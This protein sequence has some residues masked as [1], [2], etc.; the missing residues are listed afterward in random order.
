MNLLLDK[1]QNKS[2]NITKHT[3]F[4]FLLK[5]ISVLFSF[6]TI[7]IILNLLGENDYG[8]WLTLSSITTWLAYLDI[9]LGNGL[10]N[11]LSI[12]LVKNDKILA[13]ELIS[14]TYFIFTI[15]IIFAVLII[16][17]FSKFLSWG[18]ILNTNTN[19]RIISNIIVILIISTGLKLL[20]E[21]VNAIYLTLDKSYIKTLSETLINVATFFL[22]LILKYLNF[23]EFTFFTLVLSII[24]I[25]ILGYFNF[26]LYNK[27]SFY[28]F[29]KPSIN[30][31]NKHHIKEMFKLGSNFFIIQFFGIIVFSTDNILISHY[32]SPSDVAVYNIAF[33]YLSVV[34]FSFSIV[35][36]P[37]WSAFTKSFL[38]EDVLWLKNSFKKLLIIW[39]F[40]IIFVF[41]LTTFSQFLLP[42][43]I[44]EKMIIPKSLLFLLG[45][46]TIIFNWNNIYANF[47]NGIAKIKLQ[48]I[49][50]C[51]VG[52]IN[53]PLTILLIEKT[54]FGLNSIV[55][56]NTFCLFVSAIWS[57]I[58]T[59]KLI[60]KKATGIWAK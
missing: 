22:I 35:L 37:Y 29:L 32:F 19:P 45:L 54:K 12:A 39:F 21:L 3:I 58:Q 44:G 52:A 47:L 56:V 27:N 59:Y 4:N 38:E 30:Y 57:P 60:Y 49:S 11:K 34:T 55:L 40:E 43:W 6:L 5:F 10:R 23:K 41:C 53:I 51:I 46:Y 48:L 13:R 14:T 9:G 33:K 2:T 15:I 18:T 50:A 36:M 1:S 26:H 7:P 28:N 42:L 25:L 24:P 8:V 16:V 20:L 17:L 31:I